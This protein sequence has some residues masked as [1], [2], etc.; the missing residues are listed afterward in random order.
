MRLD[1][2]SLSGAAGKTGAQHCR[3]DGRRT[4]RRQPFTGDDVTRLKEI[5]RTSILSSILRRMMWM[6]I[7]LPAGSPTPQ[8]ERVYT[9]PALHRDA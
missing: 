6:R 2:V 9:A 7:R 3:A 4:L 5:G 1:S 8:R